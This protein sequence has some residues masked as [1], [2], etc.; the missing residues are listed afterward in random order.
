MPMS[1]PAGETRLPSL[2]QGLYARALW[3]AVPNST[4]PDG[5]SEN[6]A[7]T[8]IAAARPTVGRRGRFA[9]AAVTSGGFV[10]IAHP[11]VQRPQAPQRRNSRR[12]SRAS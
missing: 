3:R 6:R 5:F 11:R 4:D 2:Q 8:S 12:G 9:S 1:R 7:G 10:P